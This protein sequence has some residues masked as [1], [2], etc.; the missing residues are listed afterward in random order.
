MAP[1][2]PPAP[3]L[4]QQHQSANEFKTSS[5]NQYINAAASSAASVFNVGRNQFSANFWENYEH[6]CALQSS[7]PLQSIK[8][9]ISI[10]GSVNLSL[11]ADKL[12]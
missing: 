5:S 8:S 11:N 10:D 3:M 6:L 1:P 9:C 12:K 7:V 2:L 4:L